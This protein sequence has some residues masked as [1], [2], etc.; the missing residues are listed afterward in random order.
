MTVTG[1][2]TETIVVQKSVTVE[3]GSD[4]EKEDLEQLIREKAYEETIL[5][6]EHLHGWTG[7]DCVD[8]EIE[9]QYAV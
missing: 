3:C 4:I 6:Y 7:L 9:I 2:I 8:V 1:V 5:D